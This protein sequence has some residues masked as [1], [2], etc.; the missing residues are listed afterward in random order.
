VV[1]RLFSDFRRAE[2]GRKKLHPGAARAGLAAGQTTGP[3]WRSS[4]LLTAKKLEAA[5]KL[6]PMAPRLVMSPAFW[7]CVDPDVILTL[8]GIAEDSFARTRRGSYS[9]AKLV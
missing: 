5:A 6:A 3:G 4:K 9:V 2:C 8:S 1:A 7:A